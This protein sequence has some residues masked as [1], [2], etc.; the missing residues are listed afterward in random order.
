M[1]RLLLVTFLCLSTAVASAGDKKKKQRRPPQLTAAQRE[2]IRVNSERRA[3][4]EFARINALIDRLD[5]PVAAW[6]NVKEWRCVSDPVTGHVYS[7]PWVDP[8]KPGAKE[9][10]AE[11]D[12]QYREHRAKYPLPGGVYP[13]VRRP[14]A[15]PAGRRTGE[16]LPAGRLP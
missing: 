15:P 11:I 1:Y 2:A 7:I 5:P 14:A 6:K 10:Q 8:W 16:P 12:R 3:A 9:K 13:G 4:A